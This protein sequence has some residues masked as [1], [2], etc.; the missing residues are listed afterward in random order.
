MNF[1]ALCIVHCTTP[2][3]SS[4]EE[5]FQEDLMTLD[6]HYRFVYYVWPT[7]DITAVQ[8]SGWG[9]RP[10]G[11]QA[12]AKCHIGFITKSKSQPSQKGYKIIKVEKENK[13]QVERETLLDFN[14]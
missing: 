2:G 11:S 9:L 13:V 10:G 5:V 3:N 14:S 7:A 12:E 6:W 8:W 1:Y 4:F